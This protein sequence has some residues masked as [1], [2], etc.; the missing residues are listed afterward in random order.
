MKKQSTK[1]GFSLIEI[2]IYIGLLS[3]LLVVLTQTF[4]SIIS[5]K[6]DSQATSNVIQDANFI[7][8]RF[9]YDI[10]RSSAI[11]TPATY[12]TPASTSLVI[13]VNGSNYTY[14]LSGGNLQL[15][16]SLGT[17]V[18]NSYGTTVSN[19]QFTKIGNNGVNS[20][21]I[22]F[23]LTS[24]DVKSSGNEVKNYQITVAPR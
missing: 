1:K 5:S 12:G 10:S 7:L 19:L 15:T 8:N 17:E 4:T 14:N 18:L 22:N 6:L 21:K 9:I 16:N 13:T 20:V 3:I 2:I 23:R 24:K 11:V